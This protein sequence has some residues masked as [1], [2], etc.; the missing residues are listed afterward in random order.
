ME[1]HNHTH[2]ARKKWTH[3]LWEFL[4]LFLAVF[5]G[6]LAENLR[7][8][9]VEKAKSRQYILSFKEDLKTDTTQF[10]FL[11]KELT[12]QKAVL[13]NL[14]ECFDSVTGKVSS[15]A[16]LRLIIPQALGFTD[17]IYTDRTIQQLK[18]AG[19]LRLIEDKEI[20]DSIIRYDA[21]VRQELIHQEVLENQQQIALNAHNSMIG[22][23]ELQG[24]IRSDWTGN[25]TLL[26]DDNRE[27]NKYFNEI[28][29]FRG[30]CGGQLRWMKQLKEMAAGILVFLEKKHY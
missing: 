6:F 18:Y 22:Y 23:K 13:S 21:V 27:L 8:H 9:Q 26:T 19:G 30:G 16:C 7:E 12:E 11:I 3:Y 10:N 25:V 5:C 4:M 17:Y 28:A 2:T 15:T 29:S 14:N 24:L 20:A 1:V